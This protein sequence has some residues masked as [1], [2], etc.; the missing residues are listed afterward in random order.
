MLLC[1]FLP[2]KMSEKRKYSNIDENIFSSDEDEVEGDGTCNNGLLFIPASFNLT[3]SRKK[4]NEEGKGIVERYLEATAATPLK[5]FKSKRDPLF[6]ENANETE[7]LEIYDEDD[8]NEG[9]EDDE[10]EGDEDDNEDYD[11]EKSNTHDTLERDIKT[12]NLGHLIKTEPSLFGNNNVFSNPHPSSSSHLFN[13]SSD[14]SLFSPQQYVTVENG[15]DQ[16]GKFAASY[17]LKMF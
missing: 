13:P 11:D 3:E 1:S 6:D 17:I 5:T 16:I 7:Y 14:H 15:D 2:M 9:D 8:E 12:E 10:D 4:N